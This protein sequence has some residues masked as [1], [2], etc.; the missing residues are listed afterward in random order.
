M[1]DSKEAKIAALGNIQSIINRLADTSSKLKSAYIA[2]ASTLLTV[3][4]TFFLSKPDTEVPQSYKL[5]TIVIFLLLLI[6]FLLIDSY[7]LHYERVMRKVYDYKARDERKCNCESINYFDITTSY[8]DI[9]KDGLV[10]SAPSK[11]Q[12]I[13][14]MIPFILASAIIIVLTFR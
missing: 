7:Y 8:H 14:Y 4:V 6:S 11:S 3:V 1:N 5:Y 13:F 2:I 12:C 9:K 10:S